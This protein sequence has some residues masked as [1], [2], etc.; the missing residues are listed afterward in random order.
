MISAALQN[1][2]IDKILK[3]IIKKQ[4]NVTGYVIKYSTSKKY[5]G[6]YTKLVK[7]NIYKFKKLSSNKKYY[8]KVRA[9]VK[10]D[11][12]RIYGKWSKS[13]KVKVK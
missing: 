4:S 13:K 1:L 6:Y 11:G 2:L 8:F 12:R 3:I 9:Y 10:Q 7:K 5:I